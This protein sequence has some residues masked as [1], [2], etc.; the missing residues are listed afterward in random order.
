MARL[1]DHHLQQAYDA[2]DAKKQHKTGLELLVVCRAAV[3]S[4]KKRER[5]MKRKDQSGATPS[6]QQEQRHGIQSGPLTEYDWRCEGK[7][8]YV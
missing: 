6:T 2:A 1:Q 4:V 7:H 5:T 8:R 3:Y